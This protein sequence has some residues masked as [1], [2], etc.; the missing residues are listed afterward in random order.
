MDTATKR[1]VR[2]ILG[3]VFSE[4]R[5]M[6]LQGRSPSITFEILAGLYSTLDGSGHDNINH[7]SNFVCVCVFVF[8]ASLAEVG[9]RNVPFFNASI[10]ATAK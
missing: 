6:E 1:T 9:V 8:R 4:T 10:N 5:A 2:A 3:K 7:S